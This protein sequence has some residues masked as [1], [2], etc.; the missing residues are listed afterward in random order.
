MSRNH[1]SRGVAIVGAGMSKFGSFPDKNTRDLF[2]EAYKEMTHSVDKGIDPSLIECFYLGNFSSDQFE[3][4]GHIAPILAEA[5]GLIPIPATRVENACASGATALRQGVLAV[6]SGMYD[7]VLVGGAEKMTNLPTN[8]VTDAL[9]TAADVPYEIT[10][11]FTF[12][13]FYAA[14]ATAYMARY[15]MKPEHLMNIAIKDHENGALSPMQ[16]II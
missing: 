4:Q 5:A 1:L 16:L 2:V 11:G 8:Q 15:G 13:G 7:V 10:A 9:A 12:P 6:A 14:I 3:H